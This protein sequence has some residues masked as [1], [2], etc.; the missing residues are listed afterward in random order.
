MLGGTLT[1]NRYSGDN[2]KKNVA[3]KLILVLVVVNN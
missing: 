2:V 3:R 1:T